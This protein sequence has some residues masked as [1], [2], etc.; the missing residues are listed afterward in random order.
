MAGNREG[1][2]SGDYNSL[3]EK[4]KIKV[5]LDHREYLLN[6]PKLTPKGPASQQKLDGPVGH[7]GDQPPPT[8][9]RM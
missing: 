8:D 9:Y 7:T 5:L 1:W 3:G 6:P 2:K 4:I